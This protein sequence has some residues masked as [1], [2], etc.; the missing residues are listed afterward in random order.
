MT[1]ENYLFPGVERLKPEPV[2]ANYATNHQNQNVH[3]Q[4]A[5]QNAPMIATVSTSMV[6]NYAT[7][8][9]ALH[10]LPAP[11]ITTTKT[12]LTTLTPST[13]T[14]ISSTSVPV[15]AMEGG[16]VHNLDLPR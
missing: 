10:Q 13:S 1:F 6:Q 7:H 11:T 12:T 16:T 3:Q 4:A 8:H 15:L 14:N 5:H 2:Y 9:H